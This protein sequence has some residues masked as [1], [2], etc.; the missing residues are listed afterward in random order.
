MCTNYPRII[1]ICIQ[2]S[3]WEWKT[4]CQLPLTTSA[5]IKS[6][7][8]ISVC[9][10]RTWITNRFLIT[11]RYINK[12][13]NSTASIYIYIYMYLA[14]T[15]GHNCGRSLLKVYRAFVR[16]SHS[17]Y[18]DV[19]HVLRITKIYQIHETGKVYA[20]FCYKKNDRDKS[21]SIVISTPQQK[22]TFKKR[23][24]LQ[25]LEIWWK[26][27]YNFEAKIHELRANGTWK[28]KKKLCKK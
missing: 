28:K 1:I 9:F 27:F 19:D 13:H 17:C 20:F 22:K 12:L 6:S 5:N 7:L 11:K 21:W 2:I 15:H 25:V 10:M 18:F 14:D 23:F 16:N 24:V 26:L 3:F 4:N 8:F